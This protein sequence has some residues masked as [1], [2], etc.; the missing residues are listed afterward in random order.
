[1]FFIQECKSE[2]NIRMLLYLLDFEKKKKKK[3]QIQKIC[4]GINV[5]MIV[6]AIFK[7]YILYYFYYNN[8]LVPILF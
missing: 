6:N 2:K 5:C 1:M 8:F 4:L 3:I 7:N